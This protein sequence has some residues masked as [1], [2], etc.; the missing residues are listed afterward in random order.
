MP[1]G[2]NYQVPFSAIKSNIAEACSQLFPSA[3]ISNKGMSNYGT[4]CIPVV[5]SEKNIYFLSCYHVVKHIDHSWDRFRTNGNE[6][7]VLMDGTALGKISDVRFNEFLDAAIIEKS[8]HI[9]KT[10]ISTLIGN[11]NIIT[12]RQ[13][14]YNDIN[15]MVI[16]MQGATTVTEIE[17]YIVGHKS[18]QIIKFDGLS[19]LREINDLI[20]LKD[21]SFT[22]PLVSKGD[23]GALVYNSK[24]EAIAMIIATDEIQSYAIPIDTILKE[25]KVK[26]LNS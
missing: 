24:G 20:E 5:D 16:K 10:E 2:D 17:G 7:I 14:T 15:S 26:L 23:S 19:Q 8:P 13:I 1:S 12:T 3:K 18:K 22:K 21:K 6:D 4:L 9:D 11:V 25:F